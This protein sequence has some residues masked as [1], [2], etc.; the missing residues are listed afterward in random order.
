MHLR[1]QDLKFIDL[2]LNLDVQG[3]EVLELCGER[4]CVTPWLD[5][6]SEQLTSDRGAL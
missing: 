3:S 5:R 4:I 1:L 2:C 6:L